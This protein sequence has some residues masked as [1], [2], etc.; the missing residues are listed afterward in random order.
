MNYYEH[1]IGDYV[2]DT[3]HLSLVEDAVYRRL[4]D[5]YYAREKPIPLDIDECCRLVR[6]KRANER[7]AVEYVVAHYFIKLENGYHQKRCDAEISR[8]QAKR[9]KAKQSADARWAKENA[10]ASQTHDERNATRARS[11][12]QTPDTSTHTPNTKLQTPKTSKD[13]PPRSPRVASKPLNG[14]DTAATWKAY[15]EA[16]FNRYGTEPLRNRTVNSQIKRF[17]EAVG[18]EQAP[19][20]ASF[21]LRHN[22]AWYVRDKHGTGCLLK[23]AAKLHTE[24]KTG[25]IGT[26]TEAL[27]ADRKQSNFNAFAPLLA[28]AEERERNGKQ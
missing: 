20:I 1:H 7:A 22:L 17:V 19:L 9:L 27:N 12:L 2:R 21:Y 26:N 13:F 25:R 10:N 3:A 14:V 5:S 28:E 16:Y 8:F 4:L 18:S 6:A 24:W 11:S 15:S 23:D